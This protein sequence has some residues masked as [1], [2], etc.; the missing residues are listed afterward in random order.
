MFTGKE[1]RSAHGPHPLNT[2]ATRYEHTRDLSSEGQ[3]FATLPTTDVANPCG[4]PAV[5][6]GGL[7]LAGCAES[8]PLGYF[9]LVWRVLL[10]KV[11]QVKQWCSQ[12]VNGEFYDI[13]VPANFQNSTTPIAGLSLL[14]QDVDGHTP[15]DHSNATDDTR[16]DRK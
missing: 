9:S 5:G 2:G 1:L 13:S 16:L 10:Q 6:S 11:Q 12:Q 4:Q 14:L 15:D 7:Q 3:Q 8:V